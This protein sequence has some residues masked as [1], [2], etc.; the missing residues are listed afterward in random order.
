MLGFA[1]VT[2]HVVLRQLRITAEG[3]HAVEGGL[4]RDVRGE[5]LGHRDLLDRPLAPGH[6]GRGAVDQ[7]PGRLDLALVRR[8]PVLEHLE[9]RQRAAEL[10][11][12]LGVGDRVV[13]RGARVAHVGGGQAQPL[14]LQVLADVGP[15]RVD[16]A[17]DVPLRHP[18]VGQ[19]DL[20]GAQAPANHRVELADVDAGRGV[21]YQDQAEA[22]VL[23]RG[24]PGQH[25]DHGVRQVRAGAERLVAV[26]D[27]IIAV[28]HRLGLQ[29]GGV[30][31]GSR[32]GDRDAE[33]GLACQ[34]AGQVRVALLGRPVVGDVRRGEHRG[35]HGG[36]E[37]KAE[38]GDRLAEDRVHHRVGLQ[39]AVD[40]GHEHPEPAPVGDFLIRLVRE[41]AR[42]VVLA[43]VL[44][45]DL[46]IHEGVDGVAPQLLLV[47]EPEVH[48]SPF[49]SRCRVFL[50]AS[51]GL[52][53]RCAT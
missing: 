11:P 34:E 15:A 31:A 18:H 39:A 1:E 33:L 22:L 32:F 25:G 24:G 35:H 50:T 20:G 53:T 49:T 12:A 47:V 4:E 51:R 9:G 52:I 29:A 43:D 38:L 40:L 7:Q 28:G 44:A 8:H 45:P 5:H 6:L 48:S 21:G 13:E 10:G 23:V 37:V 3:L 42:L 16:L 36:G 27:E 41:L 17:D 2:L 14:V 30:G 46:A 26:E 19:E